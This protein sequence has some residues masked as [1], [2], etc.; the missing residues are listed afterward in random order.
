MIMW[1]SIEHEDLGF[2]GEEELVKRGSCLLRDLLKLYF[3]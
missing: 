3:H 1:F 2:E